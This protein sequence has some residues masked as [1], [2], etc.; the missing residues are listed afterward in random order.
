M[1]AYSQRPILNLCDSPE[2]SLSLFLITPLL[3]HQQRDLL[4][5]DEELSLAEAGLSYG[6]G[7][8]TKHKAA[9]QPISGTQST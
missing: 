8:D 4:E 7:P 6:G 3:M 2:K 9:M 5:A 1:A